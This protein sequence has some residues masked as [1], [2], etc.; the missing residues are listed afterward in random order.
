MP[1]AQ[2]SLARPAR[3]HRGGDPPDRGGRARRV[4]DGL[5]CRQD[6]PFRRSAVPPSVQQFSGGTANGAGRLARRRLRDGPR[7]AAGV[8]A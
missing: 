2:S 6:A 3:R 7:S 5:W 4:R 1:P 8:R